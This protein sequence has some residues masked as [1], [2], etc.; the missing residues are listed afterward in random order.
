MFT[1]AWGKC[2][3]NGVATLDCVAVIFSN[4]LSTLFAF[5]GLTAFV[6]FFLGG[7]KFMNSGGDPKK[8]E[9]ARNNFI[10]ALLG[11]SVVAF[12]YVIIRIISIVTGVDCIMKFGF[13]VCQ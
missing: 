12:S 2:V 5:A 4:L 10:Y 8:L 7:F 11:I 1:E 6:M 9:S 13:L 3:N